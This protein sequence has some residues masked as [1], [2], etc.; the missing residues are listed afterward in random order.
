MLNKPRDFTFLNRT[1]LSLL[2]GGRTGSSLTSLILL[3]FDLALPFISTTKS[4]GHPWC[5]N[6]LASKMTEELLAVCTGFNISRLLRWQRPFSDILRM[7][8]S[9]TA[10]MSH[11]GTASHLPAL[12][13][14]PSA[15]WSF[16]HSF[17]GQKG[18][19]KEIKTNKKNQEM[20]RAELPLCLANPMRRCFFSQ[21]VFFSKGFFLKIFSKGAY[22]L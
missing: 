5:V 14:F 2:T 22:N 21:K 7:L 11:S 1:G 12:S 16:T 4:Q 17:K 8:R 6:Q 3:L 10:R 18:K 13:K 19:K 15:R 9:G 20:E